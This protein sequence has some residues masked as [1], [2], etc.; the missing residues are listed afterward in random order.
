MGGKFLAW[1]GAI[2]A[3]TINTYFRY[4]AVKDSRAAAEAAKTSADTAAQSV[5]I[6]REESEATKRSADVSAQT[7]ALQRTPT[8]LISCSGNITEIPNT[9]TSRLLYI[10]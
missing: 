2:A 5:A 10:S 8:L 1:A 9:P 6:Q 4:A 3:F 7:I